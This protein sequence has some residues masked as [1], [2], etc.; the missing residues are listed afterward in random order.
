MVSWEDAVVFCNW[1]SE[2]HGLDKCYA[3]DPVTDR[4]GTE[5]SPLPQLKVRLLRTS[6]FRLPTADESEF[7]CRA[8]TTTAFSSGEDEERL[9]KYAVFSSSRTRPCGSKLCNPWGLFDVH[10]NVHEWC[11]D[12][13]GSE[14]VYRGGGWY[15]GARGVPSSIRGR[16]DPSDRANSVGFRVALGP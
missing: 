6:G 13:K 3:I 10:G 8:G 16:N 9:A 7:A 4:Q 12:T 14:K 2:Q 5:A 11:W 15:N 1:L